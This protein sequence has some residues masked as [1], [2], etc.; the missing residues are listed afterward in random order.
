[1]KSVNRNLLVLLL[2]QVGVAGY[3]WS[4]K[5]VIEVETR[6]LL[7]F[8]PEDVIEITISRMPGELKT[9]DGASVTMRRGDMG[10][11]LPAAEN[12]PLDSGKVNDML[13]RLTLAKIRRPVAT[14]PE[15]HNA[16]QVG[17]QS[18]DKQI[19]LKTKAGQN[20]VIYAGNAKGQ[21]MHARYDG[22]DEVYLA[23]GVQAWNLS[24]QIDDYADTDYVRLEGATEMRI[25]NQ[26]GAIDAQQNEDGTWSVAQLPPDVVIDLARVR[27][28]VRA[29]Q[30][31][32]L[33]LPAGRE[34]KPEYGLGQNARAT[35]FLKGP[36]GSVSYAVGAETDRYV[37]LKAEGKD[38]VA[39]IHK[40]N[41][42]AVLKTKADDLIDRS[43]IEKGAPAQGW[44]L[45][46]DQW[47][48]DPPKTQPQ[49]PSKAP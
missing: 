33:N 42:S 39:L 11:V 32:K 3:T 23:R 25:L 5:R 47:P 12:F 27:S 41:A 7:D 28:L 21:S 38:F 30:T 17:V 49:Q 44:P 18:Y 34:L 22:Q 9:D 24:H 35:V 10:W 46:R 16:L 31:I 13:G 6:T 37:Y 15:N 43:K 8:S 4:S 40:F 1:M 29:A 14:K 48:K 26:H 45:P 20:T 2:L 36:S 19:R